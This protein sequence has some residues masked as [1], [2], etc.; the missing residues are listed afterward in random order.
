[1]AVIL[2][3]MQGE[4]LQLRASEA[5]RRLNASD[6]LASPVSPHS[7]A[8]RRMRDLAGS[9]GTADILLYWGV[10]QRPYLDLPEQRFL[11][12]LER[13]RH[14][15]SECLS[16]P[17]RLAILFTD[18]HAASNGVPRKTIEAYH[19]SLSAALPGDFTLTSMSTI[20][21]PRSSVTAYSDELGLQ[22]LLA[23]VELQ[24]E[25]LFGP[26]E[27]R[28]RAWAYIQCNLRE[29]PQVFDAYPKALFLHF[30][31]AELKTMLPSLPMLLGTTGPSG[32]M[33]KPWF[34]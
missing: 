28:S 5:C 21:P 17:V 27:A 23:F 18:T 25:R 4:A 6:L 12:R 31:P 8:G 22:R 30:G 34:S 29:A 19:A 14:L 3:L 32:Q 20:A 10:W 11:A 7:H 1:M 2:E 13:L 15:I 9:A 33:R 26:K 16:V 24:A